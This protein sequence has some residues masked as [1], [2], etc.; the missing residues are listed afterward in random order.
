MSGSKVAIRLTNVKKSYRQYKTNMQKIRFLLLMREAGTKV[1][2][3]DDISFE[4]KKGEKVAIIGGPQSGKSTL[5]RILAGVIR[6]DSGKAKIWGSIS[7]ILSIR[8]AFDA[9]MTGKDNYLLMSSALGRSEEEIKELE[10]GVFEFAQLEQYKNEVMRTFE[11][12]AAGR[13]GFAIA[14]AVK[15][16]VILYDG[17]IALGSRQW[18]D[19]GLNRL[20]E[21]IAGDTT[22]VMAVTRPVDAAALCERGIVLYDGRIVFDGDFGE[23]A[24]YYRKNCRQAPVREQE[25]HEETRS[26]DSAAGDDSS[27]DG[28]AF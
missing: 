19:A 27:G 23:A 6:P 22:F 25:A 3:L 9:A 13:L 11:R 5:M 2:V 18:N 8:M 12:G 17:S 24:E 7:P 10:D 20:K 21:L 15:K 28:S 4:I 16:D 14:T 26:E 1:D